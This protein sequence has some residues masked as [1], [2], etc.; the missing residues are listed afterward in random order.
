M[1]AWL[2]RVWFDEA[3]GGAVLRPLS[4]LYAVVRCVRILLFRLGL[5]S[6]GHPGVPVVVVGNL[7]VGGS[8]KTPLTVW[9]AG[10]LSARRLRVGIVTRG[11][12]GRAQGPI[13]VTADSDPLEVG[14][15]PVL[16]ARRARVP[17]VVARRRLEGARRLSTSC[18]LVI[19]DDGLQHLALRRDF[20]IVVIDGRRRFGNGR[21]LPA[22]PLR[23]PPSRAARADAVVVNGG[24]PAYGE[25]GMRLVVGDVIRL[26]DGA[27]MAL[28]AF[29][30]R[31]VHAVAGI[32][33]PE[34]F[35]R[36]LE[37]AGVEVLRHPLP[38]HA[39]ITPG[40]VD[41]GDERPVLMTEK[42]AVK[43]RRF[44]PARLHY[45]EVEACID[46]AAATA[47]LDRI[48]ALAARP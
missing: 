17:V 28:D 12:G 39:A 37:A 5:L 18:D 11:H 22:G 20:E 4:V 43:C 25:I 40:E 13:A 10:A 48:S 2:E 29:A 7:T 8:G 36:T 35:F 15:E 9:L 21:L 26:A 14:D 42:D 27:R 1:R 47:L 38:D 30:G 6:S 24:A 34:R 44:P 33:D 46:P 32:G 19:A 23:D 31:Q 3:R 16:L 45:L 41:F